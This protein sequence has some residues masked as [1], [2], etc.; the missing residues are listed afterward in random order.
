MNDAREA[1]LDGPPRV[2][3]AGEPPSAMVTTIVNALFRAGIYTVRE[4]VRWSARDLQTDV[5]GIGQRLTDEI[6]RILKVHGLYLAG[7]A[8]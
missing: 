4:L 1:L 7:E 3:W 8:P 6:R 5:R 2:L